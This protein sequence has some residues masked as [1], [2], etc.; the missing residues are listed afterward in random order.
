MRQVLVLGE[1]TQSRLV[2][3]SVVQNVSTL[4]G[5]LVAVLASHL[6]GLNAVDAL[7]AILV[8]VYGND[9]HAYCIVQAS[10]VENNLYVVLLTSLNLTIHQSLAGINLDNLDVVPLGSN[11]FLPGSNLLGQLVVVSTQSVA[12]VAKLVVELAIVVVQLTLHGVVRSDGSDRVLDN[13]HPTSAVTLR[14]ASIVERHDLVLQQAVDSSSIELVLMSLVLVCA[15]LGKSPTSTL[16]VTL[17]PPTV[18]Y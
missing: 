13:L 8:G 16:A 5:E 14:V 1:H 3:A 10:L 9:F 2:A 15:L 18:K 6:H 7:H 17:E 11:L 4:E 12:T